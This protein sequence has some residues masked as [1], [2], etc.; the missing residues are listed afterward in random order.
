MAA[1]PATDAAADASL[2]ARKEGRVLPSR[3]DR[4]PEGELSDDA[5]MIRFQEG[6]TAAFD[7][8][9]GRYSGPLTGYFYQKLRDRTLAEDLAQDTLL[10]IFEHAWDYIPLGRFKGWMYRIAYNLMVDTTR[11]QK[12]DVLLKT[13]RGFDADEE[14]RTA[15]FVD[16]ML[17]PDVIAETKEARN[18]LSSRIESLVANLPE[19]QRETVV[20]HYYN[21]VPLPE[22]AD[23]MDTTLSTCKSRLRLAREK[24]GRLLQRDHGPAV[25]PVPIPTE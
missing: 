12:N 1:V 21:N 7:T 6:D 25:Q 14:D 15:R 13:Y 11:R 2:A 20:L 18:M 16:S 10:K 5:L 3:D 17:P 22:V 24:L 8:L 23:I 9:A 4:T 19:T